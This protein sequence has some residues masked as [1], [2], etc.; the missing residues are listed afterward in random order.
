MENLPLKGDEYFS[1]GELKGSVSASKRVL[2][3][4][5]KNSQALNNLGSIQW[6][7]GDTLSA[8]ITFRKALKSN[9]DD[10]DMHSA[11]FYRQQWQRGDFM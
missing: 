11:T 4:D 5:P 8:M 6:K 9:P 10:A 3:L 2:Q 1:K 7:L